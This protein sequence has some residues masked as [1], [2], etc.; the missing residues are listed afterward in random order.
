VLS[1]IGSR[2]P[3]SCLS[4]VIRGCPR[5]LPVFADRIVG[6]LVSLSRFKRS[7]YDDNSHRLQANHVK[8]ARRRGG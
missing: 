2:M 8:P 4:R 3:S 7:R 6:V 1:R 5:L